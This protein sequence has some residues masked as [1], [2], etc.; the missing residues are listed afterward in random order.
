MQRHRQ[1]KRRLGREAH[2]R[3]GKIEATGA[4]VQGGDAFG[5]VVQIGAFPVLA[6][7]QVVGFGQGE[8]PAGEGFLGL[9]QRPLPGK[10]LR[11]D[12]LDG[13]QAVL[14]PVIQLV[15]QQP[16]VQFGALA[17]GD[18]DHGADE[19]LGLAVVAEEH[20]AARIHPPLD[21]IIAAEGAELDRVFGAYRGIPRLAH[22]VGHARPVVGM[23]AGLEGVDVD[24][25]AGA[26]AH[27]RVAA[28]GPEQL[29]GLEVEIPGA[30]I[31]RVDRQAQGLFLPH[32]AIDGLAVLGDVGS[33]ADEAHALVAFEIAP[34]EDPDP[35]NGAVAVAADAVFEI[36]RAIAGRIGG[37]GH[38][39]S[40]PWSVVGM[41][42]TLEGLLRGRLVG[43]QAKN[44]AGAAVPKALADVG[45]V[46][47]APQAGGLGGQIEVGSRGGQLSLDLLALRDVDDDPGVAGGLAVLAQIGLAPGVDP[48]RR[49]VGLDQAVFLG[50]GAALGGGLHGDL[51]DSRAVLGMDGGRIALDGK[52]GLGEL[53]RDVVQLGVAGVGIDLVGP[54]VPLPGS[55]HAGDLP[56]H[57]IARLRVARGL[58]GRYGA[59]DLDGGDQHP[60]DAALDR[61]VRNGTIGDREVGALGR[62]VPDQTHRQVLEGE[63]PAGPAQDRL[64]DGA[65]GGAHRRRRRRE[66]RAQGVWMTVRQGRGI[67]VVIDQGQGGAP[68]QGHGDAGG[69]HH[70]G[71]QSQGGG[72]GLARTQRRS[73]PIV[74]TDAGGHVAASRPFAV[75]AHHLDPPSGPSTGWTHGAPI[76]RRDSRVARVNRPSL[77][78]GG[79]ARHPRYGEV[80]VF[81]AISRSATSA[82]R[83]ERLAA[84]GLG[85]RCWP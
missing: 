54:D 9:F 61:L 8:N 41:Q 75:L 12:G 31:G 64:L 1:R 2:R 21:M 13:R 59:G 30:D 82:S 57:L 66:R 51:A 67:G 38:G 78:I 53:G 17:I 72:P 28:I 7:Q 10:A 69:Q 56:R 62:A 48:S 50:K 23:D 42:Q 79:G 27:H 45:L 81:G 24:G 36:D 68:A 52:A 43:R 5:H 70:L 65:Q 22:G 19:A 49:A 32:K 33:H 15:D 85:K 83:P 55:D 20:L 84:W 39:R 16:Q 71:G 80:F 29:A 60:A 44:D 74:G 11:G 40:D 14:D 34:A 63:A 46:V 58:G 35:A 25:L 18:V 73:R 26:D 3:A 47:P 4:A 76:A 6:G 77:T 37:G